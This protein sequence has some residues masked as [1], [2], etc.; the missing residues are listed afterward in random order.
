MK[1]RFLGVVLLLAAASACNDAH[2][3]L[4]SPGSPSTPT[5]VTTGS[6]DRPLLGSVADAA[7]RP[8]AGALVDVLDGPLAGAATTSGPD[9]RF[10]LTGSFATPWRLR[11]SREGYTSSTVTTGSNGYAPTAFVRLD[12]L[13]APVNLAGEYTLTL[14]IDDSC[15]ALPKNV[16]TRTY[17]ATIAVVADPEVSP[18]S[19]LTLTATAAQFVPTYDHF[20]IGVAGRD[21][22]FMVY[23][24]EDWGLIEQVAPDTFIAIGA[25]GG[26]AV[27]D[28]VVS[29]LNVSLEGSIEYCVL[30]PGTVWNRTCQSSNKV[31]YESCSSRNS[32]LTLE[33]H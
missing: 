22:G 11:I 8:V 17:R 23:H 31:T 16:R 33:R 30:R 25:E 27:P 6:G 18:G 3:S 21:V 15:S 5:P 12:S 28:S 9:G 19:S 2:P 26:S 20:A 4:S 29:S 10:T 14:Q 32:R 1:V 24:G 7:F 13:T